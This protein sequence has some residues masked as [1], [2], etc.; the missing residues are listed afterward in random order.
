MRVPAV[1]GQLLRGVTH[2]SHVPVLEKQ[3]PQPQN[4]T[5]DKINYPFICHVYSESGKG[6]ANNSA[7]HCSDTW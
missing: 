4:M 5:L 6:P 7:R 3:L 1:R 2:W